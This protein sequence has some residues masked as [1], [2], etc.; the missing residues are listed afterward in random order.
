VIQPLRP[1]AGNPFSSYSPPPAA[2]FF[3]TSR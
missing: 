2:F 3:T 1:P